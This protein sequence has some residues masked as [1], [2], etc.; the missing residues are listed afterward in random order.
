M[1]HC[2]REGTISYHHLPA[3]HE[4]HPVE[5]RRRLQEAS[6]RS[7]YDIAEQWWHEHENTTHHDRRQLFLSSLGK[8]AW[9]GTK[10]VV[11]KVSPEE[12]TVLFGLPGMPH[13]ECADAA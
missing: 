2:F 8:L 12:P 1:H 5:R 7:I 13:S 10:K 9:D 6:E 4:D 3:S 11:S